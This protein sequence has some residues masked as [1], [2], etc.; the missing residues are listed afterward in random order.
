MKKIFLLIA[1]LSICF[2]DTDESYSD[3]YWAK[4]FGGNDT[5]NPYAIQQ[6][7]DGGYIAGGVYQRFDSSINA[8][9]YDHYILKTDSLGNKL[10]E[11]IYDFT[12]NDG[13]CIHGSIIR[14]LSDG[15]FAYISSVNCGQNPTLDLSKYKLDKD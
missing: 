12:P 2:L 11:K 13:W 7:S 15:G 5:D 10:W 14:E 1:V 3:S 4:T 6:T 9:N 8:T